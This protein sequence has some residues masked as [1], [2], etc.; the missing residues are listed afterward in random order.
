M[1][2]YL[3]RIGRGE[4]GRRVNRLPPSLPKVGYKVNVSTNLQMLLVFL[5][6]ERG[7]ESC[8]N[9]VSETDSGK[10]KR[11]TAQCSCGTR[12]PLE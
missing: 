9:L 8:V 5:N 3:G 1:N 12:G 10:E 7:K 2:E 11:R 4:G 6:I